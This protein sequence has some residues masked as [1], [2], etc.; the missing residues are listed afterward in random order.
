MFK[1][2]FYKVSL[3]YVAYVSFD[4]VW[5]KLEWCFDSEEQAKQFWSDLCKFLTINKNAE[6]IKKHTEPELTI[7]TFEIDNPYFDLEVIK[8]VSDSLNF[9]PIEDSYSI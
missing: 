8:Q 2:V 6:G 9:D 4:D 3:K 1:K 5:K 7:S